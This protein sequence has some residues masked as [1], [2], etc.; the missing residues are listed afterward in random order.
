MSAGTTVFAET[1][2]NEIVFKETVMNQVI[3]RIKRRQMERSLT[4]RISRSHPTML[5]TILP[6]LLGTYAYSRAFHSVK[7]MNESSFRI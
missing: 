6:F 5:V 1:V 3:C 4:S 7:R 2:V